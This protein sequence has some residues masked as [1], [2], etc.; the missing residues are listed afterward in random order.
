MLSGPLSIS[1][2]P[3]AWDAPSTFA[4]PDPLCPGG[5]LFGIAVMAAAF[6]C[7]AA[8]D[9]HGPCEDSHVPLPGSP[10]FPGTATA[11]RGEGART[12]AAR[13]DARNGPRSMRRGKGPPSQR[14]TEIPR[15]FQRS[16]LNPST[17]LADAIYFNAPN[18]HTSE[19]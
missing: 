16:V 5:V 17:A 10:Q 18:E 11:P 9:A 19:R 13:P 7:S 4:L 12:P 15:N 6:L 2:T 14:C 3:A 8:V 1:R